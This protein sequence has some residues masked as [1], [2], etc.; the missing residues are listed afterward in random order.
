[1]YSRIAW[2][3]A[4]Q[5]KHRQK[6]PD[7]DA[8]GHSSY[9][10]CG[11]YLTLYLKIEQNVICRASFQA[12]SCGPVVAMGSLGCVLLTALTVDQALKLSAFDLDKQLG[13]LPISKRH[14]ILLFLDCL[15]QAVAAYQKNE[16]FQP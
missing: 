10:P 6:M 9:P 4:T 15:H 16:K 12:R 7:A 11:D 2:Q 1:M 14:A 5:P 3:H 8:V 13:G